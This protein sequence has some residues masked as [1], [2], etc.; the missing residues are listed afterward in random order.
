MSGGSVNVADADQR[1]VRRLLFAVVGWTAL[2][3]LASVG[4][5]VYGDVLMGLTT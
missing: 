4:L 3:V 5:V 1:F 2:F